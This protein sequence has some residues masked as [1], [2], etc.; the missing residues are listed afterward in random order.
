MHTARMHRIA[1]VA[2]VVVMAACHG[3]EADHKAG[4]AATTAPAP[5]ATTPGAPP[6]A[7]A[8]AATKTSAADFELVTQGDKFIVRDDSY[9]LAFPARP[10]VQA[11]P[12]TAPD[13]T[14]VS[15]VLATL[16]DTSGGYGFALVLI[17]MTSEYD[18]QKVLDG[19]RDG[20][21]TNLKGT[22]LE[23]KPTTIGGLQGR[24]VIAT[25]GDGKTADLRQAIDTEHRAMVGVFTMS[26]GGSPAARAAFFDSFKVNPKG[27]SPPR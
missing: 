17:P 14:R 26:T 8:P 3:S 7:A 11:V 19:A 16:D 15:T 9:E 10:T 23:Q 2:I 18:A 24:K 6:S 5:S 4:S 1:L 20:M 25:L 27:K 22:V 12:Q 21:M 13:G